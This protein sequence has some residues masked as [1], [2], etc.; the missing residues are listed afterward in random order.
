MRLSTNTWCCRSAVLFVAPSPALGVFIATIRRTPSPPFRQHLVH[1]SRQWKKVSELQRRTRAICLPVGVKSLSDFSLERDAVGIGVPSRKWAGPEQ[2][3]SHHQCDVVEGDSR[4]LSR[5]Q[6]IWV[7]ILCKAGHDSETTCPPAD[8]SLRPIDRPTRP[9]HSGSS[10][11][12]AQLR[13][14]LQWKAPKNAFFFFAAKQIHGRMA[15][16]TPDTAKSESHRGLR[17]GCNGGFQGSKRNS[18]LTK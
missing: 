11:E 15:Q 8:N 17:R 1:G 5:L 4:L 9:K 14:F 18:R 2:F 13:F 7:C 12:A 16:L 10:Q 6:S 3:V